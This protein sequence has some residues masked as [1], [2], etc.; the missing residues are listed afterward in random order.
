M[1]LTPKAPEED[2]TSSY[3]DG[4]LTLDTGAV[5]IIVQKGENIDET[6]L[7]REVRRI[8]KDLQRETNVR[9]GK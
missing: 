7:A 5:Q 4:S 9:G 6:K 3:S 1:L 8:L 2:I